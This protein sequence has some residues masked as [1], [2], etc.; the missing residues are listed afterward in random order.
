MTAEFSSIRSD[1]PLLLIG[2]GRMGAAMLSGW[3]ASGLDVAAVAVVEPFKGTR[4]ALVANHPGL[5]VVSS[6]DAIP[7]SPSVVILAV[8]PQV[9][10]DVMAPL[11][12]LQGTLFISIAAGK[13]LGYFESHLGADRSIIRVMPNTPAAVGAG[14]S[15][16]VGN[17]QV[18]SE[19]RALAT[20][21][22]GAVGMVEWVDD[23]TLIDAV[24]AVSGSGPAYVFHLVEA[25]AQ[26]G[27]DAGLG[28]DLAMKLARQTVIGSG[29]LM[30]ADD[31][32]AGTLRQNVTSPGGT[33]QAALDVLMG[34][35]RLQALMTEAIAAAK[36]R[37]TELS[38]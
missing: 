32:D 31:S 23:E 18:S 3:L 28:A 37:S 35:G 29:V 30:T 33:T 15:V 10:D 34:D 24:T 16:A 7:A 19:N 20:A 8:K 9:M 26:A 22:L 2:G 25:M 21:L 11:Q 4:Q 12:P 27:V 38:G 6:I 5:T 17:A 13:T 1:A 36:K 14:I